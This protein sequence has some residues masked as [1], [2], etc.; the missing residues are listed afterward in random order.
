MAENYYAHTES[1]DA[2]MES[3]EN[4]SKEIEIA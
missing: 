4:G 1:D 2:C 3:A